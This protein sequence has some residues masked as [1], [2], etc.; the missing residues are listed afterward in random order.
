MAR[1]R[2][3]TRSALADSSSAALAITLYKIKN[4]FARFAPEK[5]PNPLR[6]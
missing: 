3:R 6:L 1:S 2:R 4:D 5:S